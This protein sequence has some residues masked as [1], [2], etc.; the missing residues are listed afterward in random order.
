MFGGAGGRD[1][2]AS[3]STLQGLRSALRPDSG[4]P[5]NRD[6]VDNAPAAPA[7][8]KRTMKGLNDRLSGYLGKVR[9]LEK[10]N[11]ELEEKI[12]ELLKKRGNAT[13]HDWDQITKPL[14]DLKK[15]VRQ[16]TMDNARLILQIDNSKLANDDFKNKIDTEVVARQHVERDLAE[17]K[18]VIDDTQLSKMTLESQIEGAKEE[19]AYLKKDHGDDV[20]VLRQKVRESDVTVE[21]ESADSNLADTLNKIRAQYEKVAEKNKDET[22]NWYMKK[23]DNIKVEVA[24]NTECLQSTKSELTELRRQKQMLEID[25]HAMSTTIL[26]LEDTLRDTEGR[27]GHEVSRLNRLLV[28][29]ETELSQVRETVERQ[30]DDYQSLLNVKMKLEAEIES[31]RRLLQGIDNDG[32]F[33]LEQALM[34]A[35]PP[36]KSKKNKKGEETKATANEEPKTPTT[37]NAEKPAK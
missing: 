12:A 13:D 11:R 6:D 33:A 15:E 17:L 19:L 22:D 23:F 26:S 4:R 27:Y 21:M 35:T 36:P 24:K 1:S 8:D 9:Q 16:K 29:L 7:D 10:E 5:G 20:A 30:S 34:N 3:V 2:R 37:P 25:V 32:E 14:E 31:Y 18:K 28:Q